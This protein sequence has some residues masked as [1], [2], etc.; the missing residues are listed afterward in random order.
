LSVY[1]VNVGKSLGEGSPGYWKTV[2]PVW[3][4]RNLFL[5]GWWPVSWYSQSMEQTQ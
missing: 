1:N 5:E 3:Y 4:C 2:W